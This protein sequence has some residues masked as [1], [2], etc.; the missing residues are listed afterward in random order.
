MLRPSQLSFSGLTG[1]HEMISCPCKVAAGRTPLSEEKLLEF[2]LQ[3]L[4]TPSPK[5]LA[6]IGDDCAVMSC[7]AKSSTLELLKTDAV[8]EGI[9]Y[10]SGTPLSQVGWKALCRA[11]SDVAAMGGIPKFATITVAAPRSWGKAEWRALYRGLGKAARI[12]QVSIVGG[13]T[14]SSPG[15]LFL[16]V[17]LTGSIKKKTLRLRSGGR[18]DDLLCVTGKLGGSFKSG[19]HLRFHPRVSEG[20][21][22]AAQRGVTAMMDLSD[23]LGSDLPK[24]AKASTCSF[25]LQL[26]TLPRHRG[27][28]IREALSDGEDYE[29]LLTVRHSIWPTLYKAWQK[30]FPSL[31]LT[32]IGKLT[33][34][35]TP[36]TPISPG[37]DHL[38]S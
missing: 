8:V 21:W 12:F 3:E 28:S 15:P 20:Q 35:D 36:S 24:L 11:I 5:V 9:H 29:L 4:P 17:A 19:R 13:E 25:Q 30:K 6:G 37:Y 33:P 38:R 2:F 26:D 27:C 23:G 34:N 18:T 16:S 22:L 14:V 7:S 1:A 10:T 32:C 31:P